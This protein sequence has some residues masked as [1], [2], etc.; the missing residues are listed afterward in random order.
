MQISIHH[1]TSYHMNDHVIMADSLVEKLVYCYIT[2]ANLN[3]I[4]VNEGN[5]WC[6]CEGQKKMQ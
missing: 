4:R 2:C 1:V 6:S 3:K 5:N